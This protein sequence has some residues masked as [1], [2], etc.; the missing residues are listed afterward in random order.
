[1]LVLI[2]NL[3]QYIVIMELDYDDP[4]DTSSKLDVYSAAKMGKLHRVAT[5][6]DL[7]NFPI[8]KP[9]EYNRTSE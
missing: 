5:L 4:N 3:V 6:L 2:C 8:N 1:M 7:E 9:D